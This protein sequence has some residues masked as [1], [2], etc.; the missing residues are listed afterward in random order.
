M[1][2]KCIK[3]KLKKNQVIKNKEIYNTTSQ[4]I[5]KIIT[6]CYCKYVSEKQNKELYEEMANL[7]GMYAYTKDKINI[8]PYIIIGKDI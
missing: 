7:L 6:E 4:I 3:L 8:K 1:I 2:E 5:K